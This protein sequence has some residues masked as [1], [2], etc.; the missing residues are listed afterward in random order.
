[1]GDSVV[2]FDSLVL[3][4]SRDA[5]VGAWWKAFEQSWKM[6]VPIGCFVGCSELLV[7]ARG[8]RWFYVL[9][10]KL[11]TMAMDMC[12]LF[13]APTRK[14]QSTLGIPSS[15]APGSTS[16]DTV[17]FSGSVRSRLRY[18]QARLPLCVRSLLRH[19]LLILRILRIWRIKSL[20][21]HQQ[22]FWGFYTSD[23]LET[24]VSGAAWASN[25][26]C[27]SSLSLKCF[28]NLNSIFLCQCPDL[29]VGVCPYSTK[30]N[31]SVHQTPVLRT[32]F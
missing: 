19:W 20:L 15:G 30:I 6:F 21:R 31:T 25:L 1:M 29:N 27:F 11:Y 14:T 12:T 2:A 22:L 7:R 16:G 26:K 10:T 9:E 23:Y 4:S 5:S 13:I 17:T 3:E 24:T 28:A 18:L 8:L 32:Q